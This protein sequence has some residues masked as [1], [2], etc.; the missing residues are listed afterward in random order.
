MKRLA[1]VLI[2]LTLCILFWNCS[3]D[4][5]T[6]APT[7]DEEGATQLANEGVQIL[8]EKLMAL[9]IIPDPQ[10]GDDIFSLTDYDNIKSKFTE[11]L[12]LNPNNTTA[13][14]G[15]GILEITSV[16]YDNELWNLI[17]EIDSTFASERVFNNQIK[18]VLTMP[19]LWTKLSQSSFTK[20]NAL[21]IAKI[22][23]LIESRIL[24]KINNAIN[25]VTKATNASVLINNGEEIIEIDNGEIYLFRSSLYAVQAFMQMLTLYDVDLLDS[26]GSY[27]WLKKLT[28]EN[29]YDE[30]DFF[31]GEFY[32]FKRVLTQSNDTLY[33]RGY[34][35]SFTAD[36]IIASVVKSNIENRS[37][38]LKFRSG[39]TPE[40]VK[41]SLL[42]F[43]YDIENSYS[44]IT[45]ETDDQNNDLIKQ[46]N[47]IDLNAQ[48]TYLNESGTINHTFINI[49]DLINWLKSTING[50][51]FQ[52]TKYDEFGVPIIF[53]VNIGS[54]FNPGIAD[55]KTLIP[56]N[57]WKDPAT[58]K[59][60]EL[61][62]SWIDLAYGTYYDEDTQT[63][64][65][66]VYYIS[67]DYYF[68]H[69]EPLNFLN[70]PGGAVIN[71]DEDIYLPDYTM[72]GLFPG[73]TRSKFFT[74]F[75]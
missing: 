27:D 63:N 35:G 24:T 13:N 74:I 17:S 28:T 41:Q 44:Y 22:Q 8:N 11:A 53:S 61:W 21:T 52:I 73:M 70:G 69:A 68:N 39:K 12:Q 33:I 59:H 1:V 64:Y 72:H 31:E 43:L 34:Y 46:F 16:N 2:V 3:E 57:R 29:I 30:Y 47:I 40:A 66:N 58:W 5:S 19:E 36:S 55:M 23:G 60:E 10:S 71:P 37:A 15:M 50:T 20:G 9:N 6:N 42:N 65:N 7:V 75:N 4:K 49:T 25:Y 51:S 45:S 62:D 18:M 32:N 26:N 14:L 54:L 56:Y 48:V 67:Y 38:Y